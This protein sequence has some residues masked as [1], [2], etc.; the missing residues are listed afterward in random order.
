[1]E[2]LGFDVAA[3]ADHLVDWTGPEK[4]F[5]EAWTVLSAAARDTS[6]IRLTTSVTQIP[7]RHPALLAHMAVTLDHISNGR[8]EVG[9][10]TGLRMDP[11]TEM[12]G[13]ANWSNAE[14]VDR[15]GEYAAVLDLVMSQTVST[16]EG[17]YYR[18]DGMITNPGPIQTPRPPIMM[19]AMG[20]KMLR[21]AARYADIWNSLSFK[22]TW[23]Q[24]LAETVERVEEFRAACAEVGRDPEQPRWSFTMFEPG[25]RARGGELEYYTSQDVFVDRV[26]A[27]RGL[28]MSEFSLYYPFVASQIPAF[29][30]LARDVI[31]E[32][33]RG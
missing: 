29:E 25:S 7:L 30:A 9:I 10:G 13:L 2:E 27:M 31:P 24:Q 12:A 22:P 20:S 8:L 5:M 21:H 18:V 15:I 4:P 28:G 19:A 11:G 23:E 1:M 17:R 6:T 3:T 14:R 33:N 26:A 16:F 32:L